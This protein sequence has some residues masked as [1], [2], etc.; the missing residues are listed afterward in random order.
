MVVVVV[1]V[2]REGGGAVLRAGFYGP[3]FNFQ[4]ITSEELASRIILL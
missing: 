4:K 2:V 1:V 3:V